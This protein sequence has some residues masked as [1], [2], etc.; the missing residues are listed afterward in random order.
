MDFAAIRD[1]EEDAS[2]E[3]KPGCLRGLFRLFAFAL[4]PLFV[5]VALIPSLLSTDAGLKMVLAKVNAAAAP[6][7]VS[8]ESWSLG[9]FSAPV[10]NKV[11]V[12]DVEHGLDI[13]VSQ[14][15]SDRGLLRLL[16]VGVLDVGR[17]TLKQPAVTINLARP[18][19]KSKPAPGEGKKKKGF[20]FLPIVDVAAVL[21]VE[22]GRVKVL[23]HAPETFEAQQIA[24]TVT[25]ESYKKPISVQGQMQVGGGTLALEGRVQSLRDLSKG[26]TLEQPE[27]LTLKLIGVDLAALRP[28]LQE[29]A[30]E[31]WVHSGVAEGVLTA[32]IKGSDQFSVE[33]ALLI[34]G[35]SVAASG[36]PRSPKGDLALMANVAYNQKS[37]SISKF[38]F[39]SPWVKAQAG[40]TLQAGTKAGVMTGS[41]RAK[42]EADLAAIARDFAPALGLSKSFKMPKGQLQANLTLAGSEKSLRV[43][44][45]AT[46]A[47]LAMTIDGEP[48]VLKPAPSLVFKADFPYGQW[49]EVETFH[50]KAP[51][52][53]VFGSGRFDAAV[54]KGKL[55]LTLFS[56]DFKRI[57]KDAP[58]MVGS[59]YLDLTTRRED[60][61][62]AV[63]GFLKLSDV[64]AELSPGQRVVVPQGTLKVDGCVPLKEGRPAGEFQDASF[65]L[66]LTNGRAAGGWKRLTPAQAGQP[67]V[68]RGF[69]LTGDM[70]ME[71]V[72]QLL[73]GFIPAPAQRRMNAWQGRVIANVTA[74][75]A[76]GAAK[77]RMNAAARQV[78][79]ETDAG[80]WRVPDIRLEGTLTQSTPKGGVRCEATLAGG[81]TLERDGEVVF[82]EKAA[83]AAAD[84]TVA[85]EGD[86]VRVDALSINSGLLD[87]SAQ[88]EISQLSSR[89]MTEAKGKLALNFAM[90]ASLLAAEGIDEFEMTG[91][92]PREFQLA[93]P[94]A[95]GWATLVSEGEFSG[96][97]YLAS[98]KGL[99]LKAGAA[100][101]SLR[102]SKGRLKM[103]YEPMLNGGKLRFVPELSTGNTAGVLSFPPQTRV[104]DSV[105]LT[106]EMMDKLLVNLNPLFQGSTVLGGTISLDMKQCTIAPGVDPEKGV[107]ADMTILFKQLKLELGPAL[108][109]LL[110]MLKIKDRLYVVEQLPLHVVIRNGRV[111]VDPVR[112]VFDKQPVTLGGWVAFDGT[113]K[114]L[115]EVPVTEQWGVSTGAKVLKGMTVKI[116]VSG[117]IDEPRLDTGSL[118]SAL[119]GLIQQAVG[120]QA[121]EKVGT[122]LEK[123]QKELKK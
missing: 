110:G 113:I 104:L 83:R 26:A 117:T 46:T 47:D 100:D 25:L 39:S 53:D 106:Q 10:L 16:P 99:G 105:A 22:D 61:R 90:L 49:P 55:N 7:N 27:K 108:R 89:C 98:L 69:T 59:A 79:A 34:T 71:S 76:A 116:P 77:A 44:A 78:T 6:L 29:A 17:M 56:R 122:F 92:E 85:S 2:P 38:E 45:T 87:L 112:M 23:G 42:A 41:I 96:A 12:A 114:Y 20:F 93:A 65:E 58:P 64:A 68:L 32:T 72:R 121:L 107:A 115:I 14:V 80:I 95:G 86:R 36:Q 94:L 19:Q 4:V 31:A 118:Q 48:L 51:F 111:T 3:Q 28:L 37:V 8:V 109:E 5:C 66:T 74:E 91:H 1:D 18:P 75:A 43:D 35:L 62:V 123:L 21:S 101:I 50:L 11:H 63:N 15:T 120:E 103:A 52:A 88:A 81:G 9:W 82:A 84:L 30:G 119:G 24:G 13:T 57:L 60:G 33:S 102:L 54:L 97:A 67:F 70:D 40:G 73:G